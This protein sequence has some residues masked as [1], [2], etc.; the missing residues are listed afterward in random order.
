[1][2]WQKF[3]G[4]VKIRGLLRLDGGGTVPGG[5]ALTVVGNLDASGGSVLMPG[6]VGSVTI[7]AGDLQRV[8]V[9]FYGGSAKLVANVGGSIY[10]ANMT[11]QP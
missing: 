1:M 2:G 3:G 10:F 11:L 7:A 9:A 5:K 8:A 6:G 4:N